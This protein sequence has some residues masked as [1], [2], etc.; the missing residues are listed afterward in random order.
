MDIGSEIQ[1]KEVD[2]FLDD[3]ELTA[4]SH[5]I[6][7]K[8]LTEGPRTQQLRE[9]LIQE[10]QSRFVT[11]APNGTLGLYLALLA[12]DL[13]PGS[14]VIVPSFTFYASA[15]SVIFA[16]LKPVFVDVK[17][18]T[19]NIDPAELER[20]L[21]PRTRAIMVVHCYG[22]ACEM[23][24]IMAFAS[25]HR[26]R[27]IEDAAQGYGVRYKNQA[28][29]TFGDIGIISF[30]SDK[31]ITMGEGAALF[32]QDEALFE[33]IKLMR[34]QGRPSSGTFIHPELGMNFRI[35]DLHAAIGYEQAKKFPQIL[36]SRKKVWDRYEAE[37]KG[38]GDIEFMRVIPESNI[39]PFRF[40]I[41]TQHNQALKD[42]LKSRGVDSRGFFYPM[43]WQPKLKQTPVES[44][45]NSEV[46]FNRGLCLPVH[47]GLSTTDV[48]YII[49]AIR[50]F[51]E[52]AR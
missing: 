33:K 31:V 11:F 32:V 9:L 24:P 25:K 2:L 39:V 3:Q 7:S 37:L 29:G 44:L 16:G 23:E 20:K 35:T 47:A 36:A 27:V 28:V 6:Q 40:P 19:L 1:I 13:P 5:C 22:Q 48:D 4:V 50:A 12:L 42:Y 14:E 15:T 41:T 21:S 30:F 46:L 49:E 34:N 43:H 38:V 45:P 10:T 18:D 8:W 52:K 26:L 17:K 51:Y